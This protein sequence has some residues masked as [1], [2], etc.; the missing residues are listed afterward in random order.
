[1]AQSKIPHKKRK[2]P[3]PWLHI[4]LYLFFLLS[5]AGIILFWWMERKAAFTHYPNF[6]INIPKGYTI[7]GIDVSRHQQLI[8]WEQVKRM[9]DKD[10]SV[11]FA[12]IKATEGSSHVDFF[13]KRNWRKARE[14]GLTRGAYLFF[15][16]AKNGAEQAHF[17]LKT[18]SLQPG[19]LPPVVDVEKENNIPRQL[20]VKRLKECL[21]TLEKETGIRPIIYTYVDFYGQNLESEFDN[22]PLWVAHY[23]R[24]FWKPRI[25]RNWSFWQHSES[26]RVNGIRTPVDFNVFNGDSTDFQKMLIN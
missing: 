11:R 20:L 10:I 21:Q 8:S 12:F 3:Y 25:S 22:Y 16:P 14:N 1:M 9:K 19:D 6:G 2:K 23:V 13:F 18:V 26:G 24:Y 17:F 15:N 4:L 7:H 5:A